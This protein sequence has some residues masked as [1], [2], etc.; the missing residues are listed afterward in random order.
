LDVI[1]TNFVTLSLNLDKTKLFEIWMSQGG[2]KINFFGEQ[3]HQKINYIHVIHTFLNL[4]SLFLIYPI[5]HN[6]DPIFISLY[7]FIFSARIFNIF[8]IIIIIVVVGY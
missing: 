2:N 3:F 8:I 1:D 4:K 6:V 5:H 7:F